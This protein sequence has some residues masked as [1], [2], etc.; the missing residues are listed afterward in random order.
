[1]LCNVLRSDSCSEEILGRVTSIAH[2]LAFVRENKRALMDQLVMVAQT[3]GLAACAELSAL[4]SHLQHALR[5]LTASQRAAGA[6]PGAEPVRGALPTSAMALTASPTEVKMVRVL[7]TLTSLFNADG[8]RAVR[9]RR[10]DER[11]QHAAEPGGAALLG[12]ALLGLRLDQLWEYLS[13]CLAAVS[14]LEGIANQEDYTDAP[15]VPEGKAKD[16]EAPDA[17]T[18]VGGADE[19]PA[20]G[21]HRSASV[22][23]AMDADETELLL[24]V[25]PKVTSSMAGVLARFLPIIE[26]FFM[27]NASAVTGKARQDAKDKAEG[28]ERDGQTSAGGAPSGHGDGD[29]GG[30]DGDDDG[31]GNG[32]VDG[33][34]DRG[35]GGGKEGEPEKDKA[36]EERE[37]VA[38]RLRKGLPLPDMVKLP[39]A[40][41]RQS[42]TYNLLMG[43]GGEDEDS[44][45]VQ[46]AVAFMQRHRIVV[47]VLLRQ[48]PV[49]LETSLA[50]IVRIPAC[51]MAMSFDIKRTYF[52]N[53]MRRLRSSARRHGSVR[54]TVRRDN[55]FQ[56]SFHY[57]RERTATEM[58][59]RIHI[60]FDGE[61]GIDAGGLTREWYSVLAR[62]MFNPNYCLFIPAS[63]GATMQPNPLS[64]WNANHLDYFKFIGRIIGKAC[65]DGQLLEAHFT[66][67]FYKHILGQPVDVEDMQSIEPDYFNNLKQLLNYPVEDLGLDLTFT[68]DRDNFGKIESV[69][70]VPGGANIPVTDV[71]KAQYVQL[72]CHMRMTNAIRK[73]V[74][75]FLEGFHELVPAEVLIFTPKELELLI[76]GMPEIDLDDLERNTEY[77]GYR[78][79]DENV[80]WF[81]EA[82]RS[83]TQS[84]RALFLQFVTGTSKVPIDGFGSLQGMRGLQRFTIHKH[85]GS[86]ETL[87]TAHTCFNTIDLPTYTSLDETKAK[88]LTAVKSCQTFAFA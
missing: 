3:L 66:H 45:S 20:V 36:E 42:S 55:I 34:G 76:C 16:G 74:E 24:D 79:T 17:D 61:E 83:F 22:G 85:F 73:Q 43:A 1:M 53:Y 10:R 80:R 27:V 28:A 8:P 26:V 77:D 72:V 11:N 37:A 63:D 44:E 60:S 84:E 70:L 59:G 21:R 88:I 68:M 64:N 6:S 7:Q 5:D 75:A 9:R 29:D 2:A 57:L 71:N 18:K 12:A 86:H 47:N 23:S 15:L 87:P 82:L 32:D 31:D 50:P 13:D 46:R 4:R 14:V 33:D 40:K 81:W 30:D 39:G 19:P 58:R 78:A 41:F 48:N 65:A 52:R 51:R 49:L 38:A 25:P 54:L 62:E 56:D 35:S 67:S 69:E